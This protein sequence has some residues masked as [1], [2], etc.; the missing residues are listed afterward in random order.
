MVKINWTQEAENWLKKIFGYIAY[1]NRD[2]AVRVV[3]EIYKKA[4][5]LKEFPLIGYKLYDWP[6]R[7]IRVLLYGHY[8]IAYLI[9]DEETIDIL[10]V[11][12]GALNLE[13]YLPKE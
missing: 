8:R 6:T 1:D 7:H 4:E 5:I 12:H 13:N 11:F 2:A 3:T 10:G 9:K